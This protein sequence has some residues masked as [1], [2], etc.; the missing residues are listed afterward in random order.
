MLANLKIL[1]LAPGQGETPVSNINGIM[2][3]LYP[4]K[5]GTGKSY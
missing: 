5:V 3:G 2:G 1:G 4:V